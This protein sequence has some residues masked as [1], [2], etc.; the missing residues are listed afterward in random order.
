MS[1]VRSKSGLDRKVHYWLCAKHIKHRMYPKLKGNPDILLKDT[2]VCVF[3][4][5]CFWHGCP[6]HYREPK[7]SFTGIDWSKKIMRNKERD[8]KRI[9]LPYKW[10]AIWEHSIKSGEFKKMLESGKFSTAVKSRKRPK[11]LDKRQ[12]E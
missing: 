6:L 11:E 12:G 4:D 5:S 7:S 3:L 1:R 10:I 2:G 8:A 9:N